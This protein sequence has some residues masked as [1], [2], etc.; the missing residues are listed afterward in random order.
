MK[1]R[2]TTYAP[3]TAAIES[4]SNESILLD[5]CLLS[6]K[7]IEETLPENIPLADIMLNL[8]DIIPSNDPEKVL[9]DE[10]NGLK[11]TMNFTKN[12]PCKNIA[13]VVISITN[14][15]KFPVVDV[16]LEAL[17][18]EKVRKMIKY[19]QLHSNCFSYSHLKLES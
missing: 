17:S 4:D 5:S 9:L 1:E 11:I 14:K 7:T 19:F 16:H 13:V 12:K 8:D 10:E 18:V 15:G 6:V 3:C 2:D